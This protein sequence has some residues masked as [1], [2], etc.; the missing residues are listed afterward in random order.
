MTQLPVAEDRDV[1]EFMRAINEYVTKQLF[2]KAVEGQFH[3][4]EKKA[5]VKMIN[6]L[7]WQ[8]LLNS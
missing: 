2:I 1:L 6:K 8:D 3:F 7:H 4:W 5:I